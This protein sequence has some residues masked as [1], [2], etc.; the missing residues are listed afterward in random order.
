VPFVKAV[1]VRRP[2]FLLQRRIKPGDPYEGYWEL[3]GGKMR[4]GETARLALEREIREEAGM[5]LDTVLGQPEVALTD[6]F[7]RT[8]SLLTPLVTVEISSGPWPFL[9]LY[10]ACE[11]SGDPCATDEGG[12]HRWVTPTAFSRE[13]LEQSGN[14][15]AESLC[16]TLDLLALRAILSEGSGLRIVT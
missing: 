15:G 8:A 5:K 2:H 6:R 12:H 14:E 13:F 7:G 10:F 16:T 1:I 11:A 9:G 3:P 4:R